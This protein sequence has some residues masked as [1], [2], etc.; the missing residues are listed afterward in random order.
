MPADCQ[1]NAPAESKIYI[2]EGE[3]KRGWEPP[4]V[5]GVSGD[6]VAMWRC[7]LHIGARTLRWMKCFRP[8]SEE[9]QEHSAQTLE[10]VLRNDA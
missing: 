8:R 4:V 2:G 6:L 10:I 9:A 5:L 7:V 3:S 1:K